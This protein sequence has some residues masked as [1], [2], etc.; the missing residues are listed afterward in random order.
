MSEQGVESNEFGI[1]KE[2][3]LYDS[4]GTSLYYPES[5][6]KQSIFTWRPLRIGTVNDL[7]L[8]RGEFTSDF[9]YGLE[10]YIRTTVPESETPVYI[11]DRHNHAYYGWCEA[12][13][14]GRIEKGATLVHIDAHSDAFVTKD[15]PPP[16]DSLEQSSAYAKGLE[17][18]DF[19]SPA[20]KKGLVN[21]FIWVTPHSFSKDGML[22][23]YLKGKDKYLNKSE[24]QVDYLRIDSSRLEAMTDF[25]QRLSPKRVIVDI[26]LDYFVTKQGS[27]LETDIEIMKKIIRLAGAVTVAT[28]PGFIEGERA[29]ELAKR[30]LA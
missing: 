22:L 4:H 5:S 30:I 20:M 2:P 25:L 26:D 27:Q 21:D 17:I 15:T 24:P 13:A 7:K 8:I 29:I 28:S 19:I 9:W 23:Q 14:Q 1:G 6:A 16:Y 18:A 10:S 12:F 11:F 3:E